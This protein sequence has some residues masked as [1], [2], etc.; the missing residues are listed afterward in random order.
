MLRRLEVIATELGV[1]SRNGKNRAL[2]TSRDCQLAEFGALEFWL[3]FHA[4]DSGSL[5][6]FKA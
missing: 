5:L 3:R 1:S 2:A 6:E 4:L